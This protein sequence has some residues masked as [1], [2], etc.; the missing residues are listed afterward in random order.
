[1]PDDIAFASLRYGYDGAGT[2]AVEGHGQVKIPI[3]ELFMVVRK[4]FVNEVMHSQYS[5]HVV[6]RH[7]QMFSTVKQL[8]VWKEAVEGDMAEMG[9]Q[10]GH[11]PRFIAK[12]HNT[13]GYIG[14]Q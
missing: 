2:A 7:K 5:G 6:Q 9:Q 3:V 11:T 1:M 14:G 10:D 8:S 4:Q 12:L 13:A